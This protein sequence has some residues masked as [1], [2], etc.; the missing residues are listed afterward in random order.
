MDAGFDFA[1][2]GGTYSAKLERDHARLCCGFGI[3]VSRYRWLHLPT[4]KGGTQIRWLPV[5][6]FVR[7]IVQAAA[8]H[9]LQ[10]TGCDH[11]LPQG[12]W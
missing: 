9:R 11:P 10:S 7:R 2:D 3:T 4:K 6:V 8:R 5:N 1:M 12:Q